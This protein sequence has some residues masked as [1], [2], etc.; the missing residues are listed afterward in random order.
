MPDQRIE[1]TPTEVKVTH[2]V[3]EGEAR[4]WTCTPEQAA[5]MLPTWD[6]AE[7]AGAQRMSR[8]DQAAIRD[9]ANEAAKRRAR[10]EG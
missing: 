1:V 7:L 6:S 3:A 10:G 4:A 8:G 5:K 9:A 2:E